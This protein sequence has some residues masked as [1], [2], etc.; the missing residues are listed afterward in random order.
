MDY[1]TMQVKMESSLKQKNSGSLW[2]T[3]E[4]NNLAGYFS[5]SA[6]LLREK[7][8]ESQIHNFRSFL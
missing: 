2:E 6:A 5:H 1:R 8:T 3:I 4:R 7:T